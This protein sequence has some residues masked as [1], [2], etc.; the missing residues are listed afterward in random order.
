[1]LGLGAGGAT[2]SPKTP[3][4]V[5]YLTPEE[6]IV[7]DVPT[8]PL[9][10]TNCLPLLQGEL[11]MCEANTV[12]KCTQ[13][14]GSQRGVY[15][16]LICTNL[17]ITFLCDEVPDDNIP[18]F[19]NKIV[20]END[21]TLQ[22]VDQL[23][24]VFD[25]K[26]KVPINKTV[27]TKYPERLIIY[28]KDFRVFHFC[29]SYVKEE[30]VKRIV[31]GI[32]HY[33]LSPKGLKHLFL[34]SYA[35]NAPR[36]AATCTKEQTIMFESSSDWMMELERTKAKLNYKVCS[37][38]EYYRRS[39]GLPQHFVIPVSLPEDIMFT[40]QGKGIPIWCWSCQN[41]SALLKMSSLQ[42]VDDGNIQ[43]QKAFVDRVE[44]TLHRPPYEEVRIE[45]LSASL[46][47]LSEIQTSY[48]RFKQLFLID[49]SSDFWD[50]DLKWFT[51]LDTSNWL[52]IVR[53]CLKKAIEVIEY[54]DTQK[55][56]VVLKEDTGSDFCCVISSLVQ[57]M[58]DPY[59][60]T[61]HGFQSLIQKEWV[62]GGHC[63]LDRCNHLRKNDN[64][65]PV[66][67]LFLDCVW[68]L[69]QQYPLAFEISE[70]YLTVL[71]DSINIPIFSTFF[72]NSPYQKYENRWAEEGQ[73]R[74]DEPLRFYNVWDWSVQFELKA[75]SFLTNPLYVEK[76][77]HEK[78]L[79]KAQRSK[80]IRQLSLPLTQSKPSN[81]KGFFRD[82]TGPFIKNLLGKRISKL[83]SNSDDVPGTYRAFYE[84]WHRKPV[85]FHGLILPHIDGPD[86]RIWAQ[87]H[88]RW[89][90]EAQVLGGGNVSTM[91]RILELMEEIQS[92]KKKIKEK[93]LHDH[94]SSKET[95]VDTRRKRSVRRS[96]LYPFAML[97]ISSFRP[98]IAT[99][100]WRSWDGEDELVNREDELVDVEEFG[101][102]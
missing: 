82:E 52:E 85:D 19:K 67:L 48:N 65:A 53:Q 63:F 27:L 49:N 16:R 77:K 7:K 75:L 72:F 17:K 33:V 94:S 25:D 70:T 51:L 55:I 83:I 95:E 64:E 20:G 86:I 60:R 57:I 81:K 30:E 1:M 44:K 50:S 79:R 28:C 76:S 54:L 34:F 88:L 96:S 78:Q 99:T 23:Y 43:T 87:R 37:A 9:P 66:F 32:S 36:Y 42:D 2:K 102:L 97:H 18:E 6:I 73:P 89:I 21:I 71:S 22:C 100:T 12:L 80:H 47:S 8:Q 15:G 41:G 61:M 3:S 91:Q 62:M 58:M 74:Q 38:N 10:K 93:P 39:K 4:F 101:Y 11:L 69:I 59:Y 24:G 92:L 56:N 84:N 13:D 26:K 46:P 29:L 40:F 31:S 98:A 90:P 45:D 5:S 35:A 14:E 68:Q